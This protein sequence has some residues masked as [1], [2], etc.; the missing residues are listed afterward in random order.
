[1]PAGPRPGSTQGSLILGYFPVG[2]IMCGAF[3]A[4]FE[5]ERRSAGPYTCAAV[6]FGGL[7]PLSHT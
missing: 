1:M 3:F 7:A 4:H 5:F 2:G 6:T